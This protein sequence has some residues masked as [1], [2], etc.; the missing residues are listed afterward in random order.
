VLSFLVFAKLQPRTQPVPHAA[1]SRLLVFPIPVIQ[2]VCF[3]SLMHSFAQWE[4]NNHFVI[5]NFRTLSIAMGVYTP[6]RY[7]PRTP[8][9]LSPSFATHPKNSLITPFLATHPRK[10]GVYSPASQE[11]LLHGHFPLLTLTQ[12]VM[13][14]TIA[15]ARHGGS[16]RRSRC[17]RTSRG[18]AIL[19]EGI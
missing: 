17:N 6:S 7:S 19:E 4:H 15:P 11:S 12:S 14:L 2:P 10:R 9:V 13:Q 5:N 18:G 3:P 16:A 1:L 8:F